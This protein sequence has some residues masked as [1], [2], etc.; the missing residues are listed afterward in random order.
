MRLDKRA[1]WYAGFTLIELLVVMGII[2]ILVGLLLP[3]VQAAREA[4]RRAQCQSNLRQIGLA[5]SQYTN[6]NSGTLPPSLT[7]L[8]AGWYGGYFSIHVKLLPFLEQ[9][10]LYNAINCDVG[11]WPTDTFQ[12]YPPYHLRSL[13]DANSTI[14]DSTVSIFLCPSDSGAFADAGNNYRGTVGVGPE[15]GTTIEYPDSGNGAFAEI[16]PV[17]LRSVSDGLSHTVFFSERLRGSGRVGLI[18]PTRDMYRRASPV[19]T[20]DDLLLACRAAA[21]SENDQPGYERS[22]KRWF[23]TG[24]EHTL[25]NH[26]QA[27][28]G[29]VPDCTGG[30]ALPQ[31]DMATARSWHQGGVNALLGDGS[32]RFCLESLQVNVWRGFGTRSGGELVD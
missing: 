9:T 26:S 19:F 21:R 30:S 7:Q 15:Y 10:S 22:G 28:N 18:D 31:T 27:P 23:W 29:R 1:G 3:A 25:Y 32:V 20:A 6:T 24:R 14:L 11:T 13:N 8:N 2:G 12:V 17:N 5:L 16:G 4:A